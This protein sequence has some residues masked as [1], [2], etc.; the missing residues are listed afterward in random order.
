LMDNS[1]QRYWIVVVSKDP[2]RSGIAE[3]IAQACHGNIE[4]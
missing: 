2:M 3:G 4:F 1:T